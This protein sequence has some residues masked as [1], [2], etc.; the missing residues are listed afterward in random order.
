MKNNFALI[1]QSVA[2]SVA[3][4]VNEYAEADDERKREIIGHYRNAAKESQFVTGFTKNLLDDTRLFA[5]K[6]NYE[7]EGKAL[8]AI[9]GAIVGGSLGGI[10]GAG[11]GT[12]IGGA[13]GSVIG[14]NIPKNTDD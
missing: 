2:S 7:S 13:V 8:G 11:V 14:E 5:A 9:V 4:V 12:A 6:D 1:S 10:A 3:A